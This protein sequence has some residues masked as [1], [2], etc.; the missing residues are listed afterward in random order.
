MA[1]TVRKVLVAGTLGANIP[2]DSAGAPLSSAVPSQ[3]MLPVKDL[4]STTGK[5]GSA[6]TLKGAYCA[7]RAA[8]GI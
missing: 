6:G 8:V 5:A 4:G 1:E 2:L 7:A 3:R